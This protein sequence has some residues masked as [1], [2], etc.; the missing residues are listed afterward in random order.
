MKVGAAGRTH[1]HGALLVAVQELLID[2]GAPP[3]SVP[4][5]VA[6]AGVAQG[7][8]YNYFESLPVAV[9]A[10]GDLLLAEH[11]RT[12]LRV[13][14]GAQDAAEVVARS[15]LQTLMLFARRPDVA[16]LIFDSG[17]PI[18]RLILFKDARP[19]LLANLQRGVASGAFVPG[20]LN[21]AASIHIGAMVGASLDVYRGRLSV[22]DGPEVVARLLRDLG[23]EKSRAERLARTPQEFEPWSPLPLLPK[24]DT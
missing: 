17:Q 23:V 2:R 21:A 1:T 11:F 10:V 6:R 9:E 8:F 7:T 16:H 12:L 13:I 22:D 15:D 14:D 18:D 20:N 24:Q 3:V 19:Q 4:Q 5:V